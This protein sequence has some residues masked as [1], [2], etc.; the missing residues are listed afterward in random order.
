MNNANISSR[1]R[2]RKRLARNTPRNAHT[3]KHTPRRKA[4]A[5]FKEKILS[6]I[7]SWCTESSV[8]SRTLM[9]TQVQS[10]VLHHASVVSGDRWLMVVMLT[11][12]RTFAALSFVR[13]MLVLV[14]MLVFVFHLALLLLVFL[15][16]LGV[17]MLM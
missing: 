12:R 1:P 4:R 7:P 6:K 16:L 15:M 3:Y 11:M 17:M 9:L 13:R 14:F 2:Y 5:Q 8:V 10:S